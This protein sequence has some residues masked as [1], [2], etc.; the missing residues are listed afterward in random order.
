V[1]E[2]WFWEDG[3]MAIYQL[4]DDGYVKIPTSGLLPQLPIE[5]FLRYVMYHDQYD[6]VTEFLA[7]V[8]G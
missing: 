4:Q 6:A 2:V 1:R 8:L 7:E 3:V 5:T